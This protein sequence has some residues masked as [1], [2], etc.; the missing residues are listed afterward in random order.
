MR[1][2]HDQ[3]NNKAKPVKDG[4]VDSSRRSSRGL[5]LA[6]GQKS[7]ESSNTNVK[8]R[9]NP[10]EN[11][12]ENNNRDANGKGGGLDRSASMTLVHKH[13]GMKLKN[14]STSMGEGKG[15]GLAGLSYREVSMRRQVGDAES[16]MSDRDGNRDQPWWRN[17]TM[18]EG[19]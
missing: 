1:D 16:V 5:A 3:L 17:V 15:K 8:S 12:N 10:Y 2:E 13:K 7:N 18:E 14:Q 6:G 9:S 4:Q 11:R 19:F